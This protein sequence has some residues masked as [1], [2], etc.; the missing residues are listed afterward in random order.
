MGSP[1]ARSSLPPQ[2]IGACPPALTREQLEQQAA[3]QRLQAEQRRAIEQASAHQERQMAL[4]KAL[5][6]QLKAQNVTDLT[7]KEFNAYLQM[8]G[9]K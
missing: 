8:L 1:V 3:R 7:E 2:R 9:V 5:F 6:D 4:R